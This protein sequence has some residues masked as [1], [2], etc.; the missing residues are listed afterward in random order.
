MRAGL[1][2]INIATHLNVTLT[3]ALR[4]YL[5]DHPDVVDPRTYLGAGRAALVDEVA[6]LIGVIAGD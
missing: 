1:T 5:A 4:D 2:K 3:A 6:R